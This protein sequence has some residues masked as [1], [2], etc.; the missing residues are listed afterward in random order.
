MK[1]LNIKGAK[2]VAEVNLDN[3]NF[4]TF[5]EAIRHIKSDVL[6]PG[7]ETHKKVT[8]YIVALN[9]PG[10][11]FSLPEEFETSTAAQEYWDKIKKDVKAEETIYA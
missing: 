3:V 2:G 4:V 9:M 10:G 6:G 11:V 1:M 7:G 5:P 8:F